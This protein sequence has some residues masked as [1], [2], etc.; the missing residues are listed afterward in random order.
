MTLRI[1]NE[2]MWEVEDEIRSTQSGQSGVGRMLYFGRVTIGEIALD[3]CPF[4]HVTK[5]N[6]RLCAEN[7]VRRHDLWVFHR[8]SA[9]FYIQHQI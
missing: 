8:L 6:A 1:G 7:D 2:W 5:F 9:C 4:G 3:C